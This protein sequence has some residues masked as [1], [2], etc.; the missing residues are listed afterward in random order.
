[1]KWKALYLFFCLALHLTSGFGQSADFPSKVYQSL[2]EKITL[3]PQEKVYLHTDRSIYH[4]GEKIWFR[5]YLQNGVT[6]TLSRQSKYIYVEL[7]NEQDSVLERVKIVSRDSV[8]SGYI[9]LSQEM[10]QGRYGIRAYSWYMQNVGEDY[11]FKKNITILNPVKNKETKKTSPSARPSGLDLQFF[12]EGGALLP[13]TYQSIAFKAVNER[14][15]SEEVSGVVFNSKGDTVLLFASRHCGMGLMKLSVVPGENYYA[16]TRTPASMQKRVDLPAPAPK[17]IGLKV[18]VTDSTL[19][20]SIVKSAQ[21]SLPPNLYVLVHT[22][23]F[24]E[25]VAPVTRLFTGVVPIKNMLEGIAHV[26]LVDDQCRIYSQRICFIRKDSKPGL[27]IT[28][29]KFA[30][31]SR[32]KV[33]LELQLEDIGPKIR[34]GSFSLS[35]V[36]DNRVAADST[37]ENILSSLLLT[38]DLKGYIEKP[39]Y[40]FNSPTPETIADLDL[41][42]L[43]HGWTRFDVAKEIKGEYDSLL[44]DVEQGQT[45]SGSVENF[46]GKNVKLAKILLVSTA[47]HTFMTEADSSG[48]F[49]IQGIQFPEK[50]KFILQANNQ[51]GRRTVNARVDPEKFPA[52]S[53]FFP[54]ENLREQKDILKY[55]KNYYY[56]NGEKVYLLEEAE[57]KGSH[58]PRTYSIY[59]D[60]AV[61]RLDS[62]KIAESYGRD[63]AFLLE[64]IPGI[65]M[66][67]NGITRYDSDTLMVVVNDF[68]ENFEQVRWLQPDCILNINLLEKNDGIMAFGE[69]GRNGVLVLTIDPARRTYKPDNPSFERFTI[70]GYQRPAEFYMPKYDIDSVRYS[71]NYDERSTVYWN[72]DIKVDSKNPGK[73]SFYTADMGRKYTVILEGISNFGEI[74]RKIIKIKLK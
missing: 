35:V 11:F 48:H 32:E 19:K 64:Q 9:P 39:G 46:W 59:D 54:E 24:L 45:I 17:G 33:E 23:G 21:A 31:A 69:E 70:L 55:L 68:Q 8:F 29:D 61:Y 65:K 26:L 71:S 63:L 37:G 57:V 14:G 30:Y 13:G 43:T 73:V 16:V 50:T 51:K 42:M 74:Y 52:V 66:V 44:Y 41:V 49:L 62:A 10:P 58:T 22:R 4:A 3:D 2:L 56:E 53:N 15:M 28:A 1:M 27:N 12:P 20:Y 47:G 38:S 5:A 6:H 60:R 18:T 25:T 67:E 36:D 7:S 40:Y 34:Q 72:P